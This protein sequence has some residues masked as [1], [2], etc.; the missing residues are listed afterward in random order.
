MGNSPQFELL[1][2]VGG[3]SDNSYLLP[4]LSVESIEATAALP[5]EVAVPP[6]SPSTPT[7][8][9]V[10][11]FALKPPTEIWNLDEASTA[12]QVSRYI[13]SLELLWEGRTSQFV[14]KGLDELSDE[15]YASFRREGRAFELLIKMAEEK[16]E[17][18]RRREAH[19]ARRQEPLL[20][21]ADR[22]VARSAASSGAG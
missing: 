21:D 19:E 8:T 6:V 9:L 7:S 16:K 22:P 20:P 4:T 2:S 15:K 11:D 1:H 10:K 17:E 14:A 13:E 3:H 12:E 5:P 18:Y